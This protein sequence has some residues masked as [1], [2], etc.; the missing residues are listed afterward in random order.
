MYC[1]LDFDD[2][3]W[4][5]PTTS[6]NG[7]LLSNLDD[8]AQYVWPTNLIVLEPIADTTLGCVSLT[9]CLFEILGR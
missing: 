8:R 7:N 4:V 6:K 2:S 5:E 1:H 9:F 3:H